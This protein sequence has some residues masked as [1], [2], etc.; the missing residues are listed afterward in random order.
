[1]V[2]LAVFHIVRA[3]FI[4]T[5]LASNRCKTI[6]WKML[7]HVFFLGFFFLWC[8]LAHLLSCT[9]PRVFIITSSGAPHRCSFLAP[10]PNKMHIFP[11]FR[12]ELIFLSLFFIQCRFGILNALR[13]TKTCRILSRCYF[14]F[15]LWESFLFLFPHKFSFFSPQVSG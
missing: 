7:L 10:T 11:L 12:V 9:V 8:I 6:G 2:Y 15:Y 3:D 14:F 5:L 13:Y 1:M 4:M